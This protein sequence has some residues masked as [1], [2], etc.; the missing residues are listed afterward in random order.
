MRAL[1]RIMSKI[2]LVLR[3]VSLYILL[4][5][6]VWGSS[7]LVQ[8]YT[9]APVY[10]TQ[11]V[12][13]LPKKEVLSQEV[14]SGHPISFSVERLGINL[15]VNDGTYDVQTKE[16]TLSDD[17]VYFATLTTEPNDTRG[18]TF[19]YGHNQPQVIEPMK[20]IQVGD[21]VTIKTSNGH[22]FR[23]T[24]THDSIVAPTFTAALKENPETPQLTVMTCEGI[25]SETRRMM[26]FDLLEVI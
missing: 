2:P 1:K 16:W 7:Q 14:I 22:T 18:N 11:P 13:A 6:G 4:S 8:E 23:Y 26:Y 24:Y 5:I 25:W 12:I 19:I 10:T 20:D 21:V 3:A 9:P 15:P 17:A